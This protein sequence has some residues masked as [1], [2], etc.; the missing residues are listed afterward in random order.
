M[1]SRLVTG[2]IALL[3]AHGDIEYYKFIV[4]GI[5]SFRLITA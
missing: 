3:H 2:G 4:W 1:M 5:C